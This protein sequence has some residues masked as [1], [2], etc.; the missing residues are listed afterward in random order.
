MLDITSKRSYLGR[1]K[2]VVLQDLINDHFSGDI[3]YS[4]CD[5]SNCSREGHNFRYS[6][7]LE[8]APDIMLL[9]IV[10]FKNNNQKNCAKLIV[11]EPIQIPGFLDHYRVIATLDHRGSQISH[12]HYVSH[13]LLDEQWYL[14]NDSNLSLENSLRTDDAYMVL[15][16][17][18]TVN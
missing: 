9:C 3:R 7:H 14:C 13:I 2:D 5:N 8:Y 4:T 18:I 11:Q 15:I 17:K 6:N 10:R 16:Q 12:G 1:W